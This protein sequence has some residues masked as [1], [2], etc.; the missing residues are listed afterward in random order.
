[1]PLPQRIGI[2]DPIRI[3]IIAAIENN[4][5][6]PD[7]DEIHPDQSADGKA[8]ILH[9]LKASRPDRPRWQHRFQIFLTQMQQQRIARHQSRRIDNMKIP[10]GQRIEIQR[11]ARI[12]GT[13]QLRSAHQTVEQRAF[14]SVGHAR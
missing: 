13:G 11:R 6:P 1:M 4:A 14:A 3:S 12:T 9:N 8:L 2:A 10:D 5:G 7:P